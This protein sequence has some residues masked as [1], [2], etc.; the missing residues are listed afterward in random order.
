MARD[1]L[2]RVDSSGGRRSLGSPP[3]DVASTQRWASSSVAAYSARRSSGRYCHMNRSPS[4][5]R[6]MP[7]SPRTASVTSS[8]RTPGGQ[9]MPVGWECPPKARWEMRPSLVRSK[10]APHSSSS[11]TRSG[12]S[13]AC[14]CAMRGLFSSLPPTIVSRK[15]TCQLSFGA[16]C[17]SAAA[18]PPSAI[19]VCAFP[20]SDLHTRPT[21]APRALASMAARRPAPPAPITSTSWT[22]VSNWLTA[23]M[24]VA[25][26]EAKRR[27]G[28]GPDRQEPDEQVRH[29]HRDQAR[30][31][32]AHVVDVQPGRSL[33]HRVAKQ[34]ATAAR[35]AIDLAA[36]EVP[37][38]MARQRITGE[39]RD[40][41]HHDHPDEP[42]P[43][44]L[45]LAEREEGVLPQEEERDE[46]EVQEIPVDVLEGEREG[47]LERV[48]PVDGR[49]ANGT[50]GRIREIRPVIRLAVVVAGGS[51]A[52]RDPQDQDCRREPRGQPVRADQGREER[53]E[54]AAALIRRM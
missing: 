45:P 41:D 8:P 7:P 6:R 3:R 26:L 52:E 30:P 43:P 15:C 31:G 16:T 1:T 50:T 12:A 54:I 32:P 28:D 22:W 47:S 24:P 42:D 20:S 46:G 13:M 36:D 5:L 33:P 19:T 2:S 38:R 27:V 37:H 17:A 29:R 18:T 34:C 14:S 10:T 53:R 4:L 49:L 39:Q 48:A 40:V 23:T 35:E 51:E 11:R 21:L 25:P 9:T 44:A